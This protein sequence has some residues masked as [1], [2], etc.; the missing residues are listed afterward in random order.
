MAQSRTSACIGW[1]T[2]IQKGPLKSSPHSLPV[3]HMH[4]T[5]THMHVTLTHMH[6][7]LY[8]YPHRT[9]YL[10]IILNYSQ[11]CSHNLLY[12]RALS[13]LV[14]TTASTPNGGHSTIGRLRT[15]SLGSCLIGNVGGVQ[16]G[17]AEGP[18]P[19]RVAHAGMIAPTVSVAR[20]H[21]HRP[22]VWVVNAI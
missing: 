14:T 7:T 1:V 4:V 11:C 15:V 12:I 10:S 21:A 3:T 6:V 13:S 18:M 22:I 5:L 17:V 19:L 8:S 9:K 20:A 2:L 16:A